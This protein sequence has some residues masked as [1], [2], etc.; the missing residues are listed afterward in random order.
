MSQTFVSYGNDSKWVFS[1]P[2]GHKDGVPLLMN[3]DG[4]GGEGTGLFQFQVVLSNKDSV[5]Q[6]VAAGE[7]AWSDTFLTHR[8]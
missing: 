6:V 5:G 1:S 7:N 8:G 4:S 2:K 3:N